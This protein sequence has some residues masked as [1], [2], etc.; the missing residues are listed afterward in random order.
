MC[1]LIVRFGECVDSEISRHLLGLI[2]QKQGACH[3]FPTPFEPTFWFDER[4]GKHCPVTILAS[5]LIY[6]ALA[7]LSRFENPVDATQFFSLTN[8]ISPVIGD[9]SPG[10]PSAKGEV[11]STEFADLV[12]AQMLPQV[13]QEFAAPLDGQID[14]QMVALG[15]KMN[16][17]T[18]NA[19]LPDLESLASFARSQG[20]DDE[21]VKALF[22]SESL[23][24]P[25]PSADLT[26]LLPMGAM[27]LAGFQQAMIFP[28]VGKEDISAAS[29]LIGSSAMDATKII[30]L[31]QK[32][33]FSEGGSGNLEFSL[34][35]LEISVMPKVS[36]GLMGAHLALAPAM[37][38]SPE[39][40]NV[41][42]LAPDALRIRLEKPS[43]DLT[44]RLSLMAG[45]TQTASWGGLMAEA[46]IDA[47]TSTGTTSAAAIAPMSELIPM[48][49]VV[50]KSWETLSIDVP[51][52]L[53]AELRD[54]ESPLPSDVDLGQTSQG[55]MIGNNSRAA[56]MTELQGRSPE[57]ASPS[58]QAEQRGL[59]Y[60]QLADRLG[61]AVAQRLLAQIERGEWK[62]QLRIQPESLGRIDVALEMHAGGLDALFTSDNSA[63][64]DLIAQGAAKL[65]D[66]LTQSGMAVASVWVNGD[67]SKSSDGNPTP[68][69]SFGG[70]GQDR[71]KA[72]EPNAVE[73]GVLKMKTLPT[74]DG[75]DVLA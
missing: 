20:L 63:T 74:I 31:G 73:V 26:Q 14:L 16:L 17:I 52:S 36:A 37:G 48:T 45:T 1:S 54:V 47:A 38:V 22:G 21:A 50:A 29:P 42:V 41:F 23:K 13:R 67:Q 6:A 15:P 30:N 8:Q 11:R 58:A 2:V 46:A 10:T 65:R 4:C 34:Q 35:A 27:Q 40:S 49:T 57:P 51:P 43:E 24:V 39:V 28:V 61:Q 53:M 33:P 68:G 62:L 25:D 5:T 59:Q 18:A 7:V 32:I 3:E 12:Q 69:R 66:S 56:P 44:R 64:R 72:N 60:Q 71:K 19:P 75:L 55:E 70:G 9:A